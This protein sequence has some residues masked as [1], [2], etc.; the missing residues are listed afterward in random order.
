M[1]KML[2]SLYEMKTKKNRNTNTAQNK[3]LENL[4]TFTALLKNIRVS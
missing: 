4:Y 1:E 2:E 3:K